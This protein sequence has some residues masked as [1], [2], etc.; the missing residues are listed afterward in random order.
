METGQQQDCRQ[1][2]AI[3]AAGC[4]HHR[5]SLLP[6]TCLHLS[7]HVLEPFGKMVKFGYAIAYKELGRPVEKPWGQTVSYMATP[8]G[9]L[10]EICSP[11]N[12]G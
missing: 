1:L 4:G 10:L 8:S 2:A 11:V 6:L 3:R 12:P 9:I 5:S 7:V